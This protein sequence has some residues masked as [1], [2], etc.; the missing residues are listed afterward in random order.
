MPVWKG[1][2][3]HG[4]DGPHSFPVRPCAERRVVVDEVVGEV[5]VDGPEITF[6]EEAVDEVSDDFLVLPRIGD[7]PML[8]RVPGG[9]YPKQLGEGLC[10]HAVLALRRA[11]VNGTGGSGGCRPDFRAEYRRRGVSAV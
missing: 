7:E 9:R 11:G 5:I 2:S 10:P 6:C 8:R 3:E 1:R 4:V